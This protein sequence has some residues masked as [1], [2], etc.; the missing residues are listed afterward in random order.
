V[1]CIIVGLFL[2]FSGAVNLIFYGIC[3]ALLVLICII[4]RVTGH[5]KA[6]KYVLVILICFSVL[7]IAYVLLYLLTPENSL[8]TNKLLMAIVILVLIISIHFLSQKISGWKFK[9]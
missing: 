6:S 1:L 5:K 8:L 4:L 9:S 2:S 7:E 3:N